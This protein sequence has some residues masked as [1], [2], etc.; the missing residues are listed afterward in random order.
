MYL[1]LALALTIA[2]L[3]ASFTAGPAIAGGW[4][5]VKLDA[6]PRDIVAGNEVKVGFTVLAH[7]VTPVK[8]LRPRIDATHIESRTHVEAE[9]APEGDPGHYAAVF[10]LSE[11]GAWDWS[12]DAY[13]GPHAMPRLG[14]KPAL[15]QPEAAPQ[16]APQ[17]HS[18]RAQ[19]AAAINDAAGAGESVE[20][21]AAVLSTPEASPDR[22]LALGLAA[23]GFAL[24]VAA[25]YLAMRTLAKR[26]RAPMSA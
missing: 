4:S 26:P 21:S 18:S 8:D 1:A 5:V 2:G 3:V 11:P 7:G 10:T 9:A 15:T 19:I 17:Q 25:A 12:I 22:R 20:D 13:E 16:D 23:S 14:V 6:I 24:L